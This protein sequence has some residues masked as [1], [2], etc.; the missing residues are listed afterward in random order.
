MRQAAVASP[1]AVD[2][3]GG[4]WGVEADDAAFPFSGRGRAGVSAHAF[5]EYFFNLSSFNRGWQLRAVADLD[6][7]EV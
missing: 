5:F 4:G 6:R 3:I 1:R 2:W 7:A